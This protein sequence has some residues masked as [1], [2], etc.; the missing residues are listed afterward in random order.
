MLAN[1]SRLLKSMVMHFKDD[2]ALFNSIWCG[3]GVSR[4]PNWIV[5]GPSTNKFR[6]PWLPSV[7]KSH[8]FAAGSRFLRTPWVL[9]PTA[10]QRVPG[11][12]NGIFFTRSRK[13]GTHSESG[14][15]EQSED[16]P[17]THP[18]DGES[19]QSEDKPGARPKGGESKRSA[20]KNSHLHW[21][22]KTWK[23]VLDRFR[24]KWG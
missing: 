16:K 17:G 10:S 20:Y 11:F 6:A 14:E 21:S 22:P 7:A 3:I 9:S 19:E 2:V 15:S 5:S 8:C 12:R 23:C 24:H 13:L 18:Q 1:M 4:L